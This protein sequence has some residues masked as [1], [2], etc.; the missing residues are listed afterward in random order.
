MKNDT[1][2]PSSSILWKG[3][4]GRIHSKNSILIDHGRLFVGTCGHYWNKDDDEDGVS[5]LDQKTGELIWFAATRSD[6]NGICRAGKYLLCPTDRGS[7]FVLDA[8]RGKVSGI[9][10]LDS[11]ALSK[12][13]VWYCDDER[14]EAITISALGTVYRLGPTPHDIAVIATLNEP[15]R[16]DLVDVSSKTERAFIVATESGMIMRCEFGEGHLTPRVLRHITYKGWPYSSDGEGTETM[17]VIHA[18]PAT[19]MNRLYVGFARN[20]Y[21]SSPP[22]I[23]VDA[24][25]GDEIWRASRLPHGSCGNCRVTPVIVGSYVVSAF[26]YSD[27]VHVFNKEDGTFVAAVRVGQYVFQQ[28]SAPILQGEHRILLGRVDGRISIV[29]L[30][31]QELVASMSLATRELRLGPIDDFEGAPAYA[32]APRRR[33]LGICGTPTVAED[34][35]F[36][37]TTCGDLFAI[38]FAVHSTV[39]QSP[40]GSIAHAN[41]RSE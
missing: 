21:Y 1:A 8:D 5:L 34:R 17:S 39:A 28:W 6:V 11:A 10:E 4:I 13:L 24:L 29:D 41:L 33:P 2:A 32:L 25:T 12:P 14:W 36:V 26:A 35:V 15:V 9:F 7:V 19:E 31:R 16:A 23:C 40:L 18:A 37:G 20:S 22:L 38:D 30:N 27:S 3:N